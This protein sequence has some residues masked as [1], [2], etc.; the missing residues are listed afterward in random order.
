MYVYLCE[1]VITI[2]RDVTELYPQSSCPLS[3]RGINTFM[4][5]SDDFSLKTL[6]SQFDRT[7]KSGRPALYSGMLLGLP[8]L[9]I[10]PQAH[11]GKKK[12]YFT[13]QE[14]L[15]QRPCLLPLLQAP[16]PQPLIFFVCLSFFIVLPGRCQAFPLREKEVKNC[17]ITAQLFCQEIPAA[18]RWLV[19]GS[20]RGDVVM[21]ALGSRWREKCF[22]Y[23]F[24]K[25]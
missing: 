8:F 14:Q 22:Y 13:S 7:L 16:P 21:T 10:P 2:T 3:E 6:I 4:A 12:D 20:W 17:K 15:L 11:I 23:Y 1:P 18:C 24:F 5:M 25:W 9:A 19:S